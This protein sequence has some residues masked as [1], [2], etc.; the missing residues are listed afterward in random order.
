MSSHQYP[1][2]PTVSSRS[3]YPEFGVGPGSKW[4]KSLTND[5]TGGF[6]GGRYSNLNLSAVLFTERR[7]DKSHVELKV[8]SAPG[9]SKPSFEEAMSKKFKPAKKGDRFGP[10]C[11]SY[12]ECRRDFPLMESRDESLVASHYPHPNFMDTI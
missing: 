12:L 9:R 1:T 5:R 2:N 3:I 6:T 8:W 7:D 11:K 10:S 4:I